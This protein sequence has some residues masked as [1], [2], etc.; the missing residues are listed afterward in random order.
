MLE[1]KEKG[2]FDLCF[3]IH[4]PS[5]KEIRPGTQTGPECGDWLAPH[6]LYSLFSFRSQNYKHM[7]STTHNVLSHPKIL[8]KKNK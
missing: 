1:R 5:L 3:H 8:I 7:G 6:S 2:L 4:S